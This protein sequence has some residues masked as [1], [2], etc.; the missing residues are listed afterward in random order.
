MQI[1]LTSSKKLV[2]A[3]LIALMVFTLYIPMDSVG[4][5]RGR[6]LI[7]RVKIGALIPLTDRNGNVDEF[8]LQIKAGI[9]LAVKDA[10]RLLKKS[11]RFW[12]LKVVYRDTHW[13]PEV[14]LEAVEGLAEM[15]IQFVIGPVS[16]SVVLGI[17]EYA[18]ANQI[19][20]LSPSSTAPASFFDNPDDYIYRFVV[21]DDHQGKAIA[22]SMYDDG[23]KKV[24][25]VYTTAIPGNSEAIRDATIQRLEELSGTTIP[26]ENISYNTDEDSY[27]EGLAGQIAYA[28]DNL[29]DDDLGVLF[30]AYQE[31]WDIL[32]AASGSQILQSVNWYGSSQTALNEKL[33]DPRV[34]IFCIDTGFVNPLWS[35][36]KSFKYDEVHDRLAAILGREPNDY[37]YTAYDAVWSLTYSLLTVTRYDSER[38]RRVLPEVSESLWGASGWTVLNEDG[39]RAFSNYDLWVIDEMDDEDDPPYYW[40]RVGTYSYYS[41]SITWSLN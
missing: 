26:V 18:N 25:A 11:F 27:L 40:K 21:P 38:V 8:G 9:D 29:G 28:V 35:P 3:S 6:L 30:I 36:S 19:L 37:A 24:V 41:D 5:A 12:R 34:A 22:R 20:I 33:L 31:A 14:A 7:D 10:N 16:S 4:G 23:I 1:G 17:T 2:A 13:D 15:G 32:N 39:D